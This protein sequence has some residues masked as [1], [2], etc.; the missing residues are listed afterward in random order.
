MTDAQGSVTQYRYDRS[1]RLLAEQR[2]AETMQLTYL[3]GGN[4]ASSTG[5][6]L[7]VQYQY[8]QG[9]RLVRAGQASFQYD[10][11]GNL[12]ERHGRQ[13]VTRYQYDAVNRMVKVVKPDGSEVS[14]G[15]AP[16]GACLAAGYLR[17][18]LVCDRRDQPA[19][20]AGWPTAGQGGL[21]SW[22][23]DRLPPGN[24]AGRPGG[25]QPLAGRGDAGSG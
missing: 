2:P 14:F 16:T 4:R 22:P 10:A 25:I 13:G 5:K 23:G 8:D 15:Y 9:D 18:H 12:I 3:P 7:S 21:R 17:H 24:V 19:R 1:G 6:D 11:N 20:R